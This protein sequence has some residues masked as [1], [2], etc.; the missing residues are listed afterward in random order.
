MD[1]FY[2]LLIKDSLDRE[3]M[4]AFEAEK[5]KN[6]HEILQMF[7]ESNA[8]Y[9]SFI[10]KSMIQLSLGSVLLLL[11]GWILLYGLAPEDI[12]CEVFQQHYIC[13]VPLATF[14]Y[15]IVTVSM[16]AMIGYLLCNLWTLVWVVFRNINPFHKFMTKTYQHVDKELTL[17]KAGKK[18]DFFKH[19]L[20]S[21]ETAEPFFD[22]YLCLLYTSPSPRD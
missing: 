1:S 16:M 2:K 21:A 20:P 7:R 18:P 5:L 14:Y 19:C 9:H 3:D 22:I 4:E 13:V 15:K 10:A 11:V 12:E 17:E 8:V 6:S